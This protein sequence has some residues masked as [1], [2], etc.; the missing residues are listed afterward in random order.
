MEEIKF[1]SYKKLVRIR[2]LMDENTSKAKQ[3]ISDIIKKYEKTNFG[4]EF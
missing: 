3:L 1:E 4:G 2:V